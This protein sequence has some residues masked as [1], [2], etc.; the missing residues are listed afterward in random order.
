MRWREFRVHRVAVVSLKASAN[1]AFRARDR[2]Q[3]TARTE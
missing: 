3:R 1:E 2:S